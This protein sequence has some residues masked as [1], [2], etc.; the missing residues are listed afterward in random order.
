MSG[1]AGSGGVPLQRAEG[2]HTSRLVEM[3]T[4]Q[5]LMVIGGFDPPVNQGSGGSE[6]GGGGEGGGFDFD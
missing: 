3:Y 1:G 6:R 5:A 2:V 4:V